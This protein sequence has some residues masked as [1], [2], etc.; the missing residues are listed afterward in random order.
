M[1]EYLDHEDS[2]TLRLTPNR[3]L[4]WKGNVIFFGLIA[5]VTLVVAV[6]W[7][8]AGAWMI[9][10]FAGLELAVVAY[11]LY[12][13]SRQCYRQE[14][15]VLTEDRMR[16]EKGVNQKDSEWNLPRYWVRVIMELP[17]HGF[18]SPRLTLAYHDTRVPL[19]RFLNPEDLKEF[20]GILEG[21]GIWVERHHPDGRQ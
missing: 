9:L 8:L 11:G 14:V 13:T 2:T 10:P 19:A 12:H 16:L 7:S 4:S 5:V 17:P 3:S 15:L 1:L 6:G 20:V 18:A 21:A